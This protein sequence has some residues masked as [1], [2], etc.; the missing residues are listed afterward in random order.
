M[1]NPKQRRRGPATARDY[2]EPPK[3]LIASTKDV[4]EPLEAVPGYIVS[5]DGR[6]AREI[7]V[8]TNKNGTRFARVMRG[9]RQ[10]VIRV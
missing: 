7:K 3:T 2:P 5:S 8:R 1:S 10:T 4:W 6:V 9:G